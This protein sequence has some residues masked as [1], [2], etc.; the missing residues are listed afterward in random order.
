M[1][2][3]PTSRQTEKSLKRRRQF[4]VKSTRHFHAVPP[5]EKQYAWGAL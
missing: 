1:E 5:F 4:R 3:N 2:V